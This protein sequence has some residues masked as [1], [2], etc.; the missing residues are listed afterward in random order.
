[1]PV[2]DRPA[3]RWRRNW[4]GVVATKRVGPQL[5]AQ[6]GTLGPS[7]TVTGSWTVG[8]L[9]PGTQARVQYLQPYAIDAQGVRVLGSPRALVMLDSAY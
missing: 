9:G 1:M 6:L 2:S 7:G 8:E 4:N 5:E 3:F